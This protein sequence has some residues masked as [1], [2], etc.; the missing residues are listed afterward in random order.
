MKCE[1]DNF[2]KIYNEMQGVGVSVSKLK[3]KK[4]VKTHNYTYYICLLLIFIFLITFFAVVLMII[5]EEINFFKYFLQVLLF[6]P[7]F[8]VLSMSVLFLIGYI[9]TK[10]RLGGEVLLKEEGVEDHEKDG[11]IF[12]APWNLIDF[13]YFGKYGV[14]FFIR[15][16]LVIFGDNTKQ[17][18][19]LKYLEENKINILV[20]HRSKK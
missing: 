9:F 6:F 10:G 8:V 3:K 5:F 15:K 14:Y 11:L 1:S 17:E 12:F 2:F 18:E 4:D 20:Y 7:I 13:A 19:I 16:R